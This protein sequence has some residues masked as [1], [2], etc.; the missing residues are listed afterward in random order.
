MY[1]RK[2]AYQHHYC[3]ILYIL[4]V[5]LV[6]ESILKVL[7]LIWSYGLC[8]QTKLCLMMRTMHNW[9]STVPLCTCSTLHKNFYS[10]NTLRKSRLFLAVQVN[11]QLIYL[12]SKERIDWFRTYDLNLYLQLYHLDRISPWTQ[13]HPTLSF[14]LLTSVPPLIPR[15]QF[16]LRQDIFFPNPFIYITHQFFSHSTLNITKVFCHRLLT[17]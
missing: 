6:F 11:L 16:E 9:V 3:S 2:S 10:Q 1:I 14:S 13:A 17:C 4:N 7:F 5:L 8:F 12:G 15:H